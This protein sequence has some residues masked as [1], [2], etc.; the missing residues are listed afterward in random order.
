M[1]PVPAPSRPFTAALITPPGRGAVAAWRILGLPEDVSR[2]PFETVQPSRIADQP[3]GRIWFGRWNG[4]EAVL[5]RTAT[6][7]WELSIHGGYAAVRRVRQD[8]EKLGC[9][10][11]QWEELLTDD[12]SM[13]ETEYLV[14]ATKTVTWTATEYLLRHPTQEWIAE[15]Q[16]WQKLFGQP[17]PAAE[18]E[19]FVS[20]C[21]EWLSW[22]EFG[23]HLTL[24]YT[25]ALIGE[26]NVGKSSL[27]NRLA[28]FDRAI[29]QD[30]PGTTRDLVAVDASFS[31][32][33]FSLTD[34]AG[35]RDTT[36][37][38][39][40][41]GISRTHDFLM[42]ADLILHLVDI[43]SAPGSQELRLS[44]RL[45]H[46]LFVAH[47]SDLTP[48][49]ARALTEQS[50][51]VSS[52]TGEGIGR[53]VDAIVSRLIPKVPDRKTVFPITDRQLDVL[54][55][56]LERGGTAE[57]ELLTR[58]ISELLSPVENSIQ[59]S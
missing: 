50:L 25:V 24:P 46:A 32:Y 18:R 51:R 3:V 49:P 33:P 57:P 9:T 35:L 11:A 15:L 43:S 45:P 54:Q 20:R 23:R 34:T 31:G 47:K 16:R 17:F 30:R 38:L 37:R 21:A 4:E 40:S 8:L 36:D 56:L 42:Q 52:M 29:V 48:H 53:L 13:L 58:K 5:T 41:E 28:G 44:E 26:P 14:A 2:L 22:S 6:L 7:E 55:F 27:L 1:R 59:S 12:R 19:Q 39:E 10:V